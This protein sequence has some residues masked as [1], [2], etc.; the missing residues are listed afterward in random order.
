MFYCLFLLLPVA[1]VSGLE[2]ALAFCLVQ[3]KG[4]RSL[5]ARAL[6]PAPRAADL[7]LISSFPVSCDQAPE[8]SGLGLVLGAPADCVEILRASYVGDKEW[9]YSVSHFIGYREIIMLGFLHAAWF[10]TVAE[11]GGDIFPFKSGVEMKEKQN[12]T[13]NCYPT[14]PPKGRPAAL[15][16]VLDVASEGCW[17]L[18][19]SAA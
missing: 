16:A 4:T 11:L 15:G 17:L 14:P 18:Q 9:V 8:V 7:Q 13:K 5:T 3:N 1:L 2:G 19:V 10:Q 6:A 12:G